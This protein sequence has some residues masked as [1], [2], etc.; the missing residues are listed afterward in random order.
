MI[1]FLGI[2]CRS[3]FVSIVPCLLVACVQEGASTEKVSEEMEQVLNSIE[4]AVQRHNNLAPFVMRIDWDRR[5]PPTRNTPAIR[6]GSPWNEGQ[7][8]YIQTPEIAWAQMSDEEHAV[9]FFYGID[10]DSPE[11]SH[12]K[13]RYPQLEK[14]AWKRRADG[15]LELNVRLEGGYVQ[16]F[17]VI[18]HDRLLEIRFGVT[19]ASAASIVEL[20]CQL[21]LIFRLLPGLDDQGPET[22]SF[23]CDNQV[24]HWASLGQDLAW[25]DTLRDPATGKILRSCFF[26]AS[27]QDYP[28]EGWRSRPLQQ[29]NTMR[30]AK[31]VDLPAIVKSSRDSDRHVLVY[32][33]FGRSVFYN[34]RMPC[35]HSDPLMIGPAV[36]ETRWAST[37]VVFYEGDV[38]RLL[39]DLD[40]EHDQ[41][42]RQEGYLGG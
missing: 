26:Q 7:A 33:P 2:K 24:T 37:Y 35:M 27:T 28:P 10:V 13:P 34:A 4:S 5:L 17:R 29:R 9:P 20:R 30:L 36:G 18:P 1:E 16:R 11:V 12:G 19:N 8:L 42:K 14:P 31:L 22:S 25:M 23:L 3:M 6:V 41:L 38:E 32:S 15:S 21:C 40:R 39:R